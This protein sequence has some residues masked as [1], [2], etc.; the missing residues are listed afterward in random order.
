[1]CLSQRASS[2]SGKSSRKMSAAALLAGECTGDHHLGQIEQVL[3]FDDLSRS[4]L[5]C[6]PSSSR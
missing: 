3:E 1:M 2:R 4:M 6:I 5:Y